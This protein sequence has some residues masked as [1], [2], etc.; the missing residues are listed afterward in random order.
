MTDQF[1]RPPGTVY[2]IGAGPGDPGLI[3]VR[4]MELLRTCDVVVYDRLAHPSLLQHVRSDAEKI[5]VGKASAQHAM[6]QPEINALLIAKAKEGKSVARLKGGDPFVFGRGGEEAEECRAAGVP[7]QIVPGVTSA[8][9]APAYAGIPVTHRDAASSFAVI[10][11]HERD[12]ARESGTR[13]PGEAEGRRNWAHIAYAADTLVF[14]M[15][16]E[17]LPEITTRL[18]Q[19][20]RS[21]ETP[22]A[23]V[24]WGTWAQ[25]RVVTGTLAT[26]VEEVRNAKL[27]PPAVCIVGEVVKLRSA[28]RWFD[29]VATRPL[30]G[31]RILVTRA[32]EQA[33]GLVELLRAKGADPIEFP[34][35]RI[36]RLEDYTDLDSALRNLTTYDWAV[37]TS[38]NAV[39]IVAERLKALDLDA[40]A[41]HNTRI[42]ALGPA[43]A[44]ALREHL[45]LRA[46]F[47]P[48][49]AV[50]EA[51]LAQWPEADLTGKRLLFPRAKEAREIL[52]EQLTAR[53]ATVDMIP[54]YETQ[55]DGDGA[56]DIR[57]LLLEGRVD[58]VTF[59]SASTVQNFAQAVSTPTQT[60]ATLVGTTPLVAIGPVTA[61]AARALDLSV[62]SVAEEHTIPGLV[63]A[64]EKLWSQQ[65]A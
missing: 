36:G 1:S 51:M 60:P 12:D 65:D 6:K 48:T 16:V 63:A 35:I 11:G 24:Q 18:Q 5:Y 44:N 22:V 59:T 9:A 4:G 7:F 40:R 39:P 54:I 15:G 26:I 55:F 37:F 52:P 13:A 20:G 57:R 14:L 38:I 58:A 3:T 49:E 53:G 10:T 64:L 33:S 19:H 45:G 8:I 2:L 50:A 25:Q 34:V 21:P 23:L 17:A 27:T 47:V 31:K 42:A 46:D 32:R 56:D 29:D 28:L 43:T 62:H 61:D 41:F 30:N